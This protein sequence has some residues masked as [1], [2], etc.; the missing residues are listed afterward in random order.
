MYQVFTQNFSNFMAKKVN[1]AKF[2][3]N[4]PCISMEK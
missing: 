1:I 2:S 3:E 4:I